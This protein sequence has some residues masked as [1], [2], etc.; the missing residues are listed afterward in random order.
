MNNLG[1]IE[2]EVPFFRQGSSEHFSLIK[3]SYKR[4]ADT[5][6]NAKLFLTKKITEHEQRAIEMLITNPLAKE[7]YFTV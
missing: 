7:E 5:G 6:L 1:Q 4:L 2:P 3:L